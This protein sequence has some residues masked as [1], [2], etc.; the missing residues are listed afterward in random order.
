MKVKASLNVPFIVWNHISG[1]YS[2]KTKLDL[3]RVK[4]Q[5]LKLKTNE[6]NIKFM[7]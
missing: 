5:S 6:P 7:I 2:Y 3:N 4:K 1:L